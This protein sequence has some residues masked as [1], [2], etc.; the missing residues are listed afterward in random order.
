MKLV[1]NVIR[2]MRVGK[3]FKDNQDNINHL[4]FANDG[5]SLISSSDDDQVRQVSPC[6]GD[7]LAG[8]FSLWLNVQAPVMTYFGPDKITPVAM[9]TK[10]KYLCLLRASSVVDVKCV[11]N[12]SVGA[13]LEKAKTLID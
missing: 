12:E 13:W 3:V 8:S 10:Y 5:A 7:L 6:P 2:S 4:H 11:F 1:D 9:T